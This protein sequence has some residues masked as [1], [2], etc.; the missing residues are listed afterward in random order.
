MIKQDNNVIDK[1]YLYADD[2]EEPKYQLFIKKTEQTG[3][4]N[5]NDLTAFIEYSNNMDDIYDNINDCNKKR[6]RKVSIVFDDMISHV[7]SNKKA[8]QVLKELF[9]RC[10]KLNIS[11]C[12][13]TQSYFN[14]P[15]DVRL[16]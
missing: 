12:F 8:Q 3:I 7:M 16:N 13:L 2:L 11:L 15:K 9:I 1:I 4:K 6:K 5:L 10:R 14:V